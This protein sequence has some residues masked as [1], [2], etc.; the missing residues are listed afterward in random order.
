MF[1]RVTDRTNKNV[2]LIPLD[3]IDDI[4][5]DHDTDV[6]SI[7][8]GNRSIVVKVEEPLEYFE[9]KLIL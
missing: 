3:S 9:E 8:Y 4:T 5:Y 6:V 2:V 1:I 7:E